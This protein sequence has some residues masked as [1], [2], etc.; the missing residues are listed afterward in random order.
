MKL[1]WSW[2]DIDDLNASKATLSGLQ[3]CQDKQSMGGDFFQPRKHFLDTF[4]QLAAS[5]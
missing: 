3:P 5:H 2:L 1:T 4:D